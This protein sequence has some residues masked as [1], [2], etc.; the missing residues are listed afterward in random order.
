MACATTSSEHDAHWMAARCWVVAGCGVLE[1]VQGP[2]AVVRREAGQPHVSNLC[3]Q[4]F[5]Q[6]RPN[7]QQR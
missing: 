3:R 1:W 4:L 6:P 2:T 5:Q 7:S